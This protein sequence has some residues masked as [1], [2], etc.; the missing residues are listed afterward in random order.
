MPLAPA[1]PA[2]GSLHIADAAGN[3]AVVAAL[4]A[5]SDAAG[6]TAAGAGEDDMTYLHKPFPQNSCCSAPPLL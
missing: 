2:H 3:A 5:A 1:A 6:A 4:P